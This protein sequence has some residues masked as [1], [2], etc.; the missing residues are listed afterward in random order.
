MI[1]LIISYHVFDVHMINIRITIFYHIKL[2]NYPYIVNNIFN[3]FSY[4]TYYNNITDP[5]RKKKTQNRGK[6]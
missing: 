3:R 1:T 6:N 5:S 4:Y 2:Q